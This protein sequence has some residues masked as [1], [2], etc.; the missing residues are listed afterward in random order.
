MCAQTALSWH[1]PFC[2]S[3]QA[4]ERR[5]HDD[6]RDTASPHLDI[7]RGPHGGLGGKKA[8]AIPRWST[9]E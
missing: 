3:G 4:L 6:G 7:D 2:R 9:G 1:L 5:L 8:S